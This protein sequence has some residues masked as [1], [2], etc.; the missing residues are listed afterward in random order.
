[1]PEDLNENLTQLLEIA[2]QEEANWADRYEELSKLVP[3]GEIKDIFYTMYLDKMQNN[4]R[5]VD[6]LEL[7]IDNAATFESP[8][9][10]FQEET[11]TAD[12]LRRY[13]QENIWHEVESARFYASILPL[14][15]DY[16]GASQLT[17]LLEGAQNSAILN[18]Y[19]FSLSFLD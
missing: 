1:M 8:T 14:F 5:M 13:I 2:A 12:Q 10:I 4:R 17:Q 18:Q 9:P 16:S 19:L 3:E 7:E 11:Y 6:L 15:P